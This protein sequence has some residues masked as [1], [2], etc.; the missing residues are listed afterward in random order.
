MVKGGH[1]NLEAI[2]FFPES[3]LFWDNDI[4]KKQLGCGCEQLP[5]YGGRQ[6]V[7]LACGAIPTV[8]WLD[9]TL[10]CEQAMDE[11]CPWPPTAARAR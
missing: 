1:G 5:R 4:L 11:L 9:G 10:A 7:A 3:I 6:S 8:A 2:A